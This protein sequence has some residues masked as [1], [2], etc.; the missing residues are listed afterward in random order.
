MNRSKLFTVLLC[1]IVILLPL[2]AEASRRAKTE[3]RRCQEILEELTKYTDALK[4]G[5][6][7]FPPPE[8]RADPSTGEIPLEALIEQAL[9]KDIESHKL[10]LPG[11][12][13]AVVPWALA[14]AAHQDSHKYDIY[15]VKHGFIEDDEDKVTAESVRAYFI[16]KCQK[17][18]IDEKLWQK[19]IDGFNPDPYS[20]DRMNP[21]LRALG[22]FTIAYGQMPVLVMQMLIAMA[23]AVLFLKRSGN[24]QTNFWAG[25]TAGAALWTGLQTIY[26]AVTLSMGVQ[27]MMSHSM[28][29]G[30]FA[31]QELLCFVLFIFFIVMVFKF[32]K[33]QR[34][35]GPVVAMVFAT[36]PGILFSNIFTGLIGL[37]AFWLLLLQAEKAKQP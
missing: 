34:P 22:R 37:F 23:G 15:C 26:L 18:G 6:S 16:D 11:C 10:L 27:A 31:I 25:V 2:T 21:A 17:S 4:S 19:T 24:W 35:V 13:Y 30:I 3:Y 20:L 29:R 28:F 14:G 5:G 36:M 7:G 1:F 9:I 12:R 32:R 8:L 33:Y